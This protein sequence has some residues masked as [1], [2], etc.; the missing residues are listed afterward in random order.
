MRPV[1]QKTLFTRRPTVVVPGLL[2]F[3]QNKYNHGVSLPVIM[4]RTE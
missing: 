1:V 2:L 4:F 3:P